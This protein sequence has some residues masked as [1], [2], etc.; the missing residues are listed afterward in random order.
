MAGK[1]ED[2]TLGD[3]GRVIYGQTRT[4]AI[5]GKL[6][7]SDSIRH[8]IRHGQKGRPVQHDRTPPH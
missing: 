5:E 6:R 4:D 3:L 1:W 8:P 7:W 2:L